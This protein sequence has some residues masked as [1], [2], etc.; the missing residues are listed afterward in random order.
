MISHEHRCIFVHLRRTGGNAIALALGGIQLY[1]RE[2]RATTVWENELHRGTIEQTGRYKKDLRGH[3]LHATATEIRELH[4]EEFD[5]YFK[6]SFV[7]NPWEQLLSMYL[8][9]RPEDVDGEG[10]RR[11]LV[12]YKNLA[13]TLP[14]ASLHDEQ[15]ECLMDFIGRY[16]NLQ[17]DFATVC[18]RLG[19]SPSTLPPVNASVRHPYEHYYDRETIEFVRSLCADEV[20][21]FGYRFGA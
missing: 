19:L 15:G 4:P 11:W 1:D 12:R 3:Y 7:R 13:G 21:R 6:F 14:S 9:L 17:S 8:R 18:E 2:G 16:E 10:F 5:G 20:E